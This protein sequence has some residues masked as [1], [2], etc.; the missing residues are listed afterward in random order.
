MMPLHFIPPGFKINT[1]VY[2]DIMVNVVKTRDSPIFQEDSA[3]A[4]KAK[5]TQEWMKE[6]LAAFWP[7][8][9]GPPQSPDL[10]PLNYSIWGVVEAEACKTSH[11]N[12]DDLKASAALA[13][14]NMSEKYLVATCR[15]FRPRL[16]KI[17]AKNG[18]DFE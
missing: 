14:F 5:K 12:V 15:S 17:L 1:D 3:P 18:D 6:N 16:K 7:A 10:N 2:L 4:H 8:N 9:L 11:Q 13:W